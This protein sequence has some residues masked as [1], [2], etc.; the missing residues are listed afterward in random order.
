MSEGDGSRK[1]T[2]RRE[3]NLDMAILI[4]IFVTGQ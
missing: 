4:I 2:L 3:L 1:A